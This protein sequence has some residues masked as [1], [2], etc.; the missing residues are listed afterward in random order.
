MCSFLGELRE[1]KRVNQRREKHGHPGN[2][3]LNR[4]EI[5]GM[6][7]SVVKGDARM[8]DVRM[9]IKQKEQPNRLTNVRQP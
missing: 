5:Q 6:P 4:G 3:G 8:Q 7:K 2:R 9:P 1:D